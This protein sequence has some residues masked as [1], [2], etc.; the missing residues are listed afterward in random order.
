MAL[1]FGLAAI[2]SFVLSHAPAI[3][4][5]VGRLLKGRAGAEKRL[6]AAKELAEVIREGL[7]EEWAFDSL[8]D[9]SGRKLLKAMEDEDIFEDEPAD[10]SGPGFIL[11]MIAG[12]M[13]G[14]AAA[15]LF[16]PTSGEEFGE[17]GTS[18]TEPGAAT[19]A[20]RETATPADKA[21]SL[22]HT[23]RARVQEATE[24]GRRAGQ[25]AEDTLR[26][27]FSEL[28]DN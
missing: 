22:L 6:A 1:G 20:D 15:T 28:T 8:G 9:I 18:P 13:T 17:S 27:R 26:R 4:E 19:V 23:L 25:E 12:A 11:G 21:R 24:E 2:G 16:A 5:T 10:G 3:I 7:D 14:A